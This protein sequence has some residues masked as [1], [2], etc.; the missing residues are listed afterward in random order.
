MTAVPETTAVDIVDGLI[1]DIQGLQSDILLL[2][3][4]TLLLRTALW[5]CA[6]DLEGHTTEQSDR[7]L[8]LA[9]MTLE[10]FS[11]SRVHALGET[12]GS[13]VCTQ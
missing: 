8:R 9:D 11:V 1:N 7:L 12:L 2:Y 4:V 5:E 13:L 3:S 6:N 10:R